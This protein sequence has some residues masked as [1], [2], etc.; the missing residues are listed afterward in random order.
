M[1]STSRRRVGVVVDG[2]DRAGSRA[3]RRGARR[4][5]TQAEWKVET[6]I[7]RPRGPTSSA[8]RRRISSAALLVKVMARICQGAASPVAMRWAMR[9]VSTRVLPE[10]AP[11]TISSGPPRWTTAHAGQGQAVEQ[12]RVRRAPSSR[13][14]RRG[15]GRRPATGRRRHAGPRRTRRAS[16]ARRGVDVRGVDGAGS[17]LP[18]TVTPTRW[19]PGG[20]DVMSRPP[21]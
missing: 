2:E 14:R 18:A 8:T 15:A 11:A 7:A 13:A 19:C 17:P 12:C 10:P 1:I 4:M 3:G 20:F 21:G 16:R 9:R 6:H 5:R